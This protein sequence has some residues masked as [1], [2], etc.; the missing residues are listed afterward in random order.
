MERFPLQ[1]VY[2]RT[3]TADARPGARGRARALGRA[4][5]GVCGPGG[6]GHQEQAKQEGPEGDAVGLGH[7]AVDDRPPAPRG[8][9][10]PGDGDRAPLC[11]GVGDGSRGTAALEAAGAGVGGVLGGTKLLDGAVGRVLVRARLTVEPAG[12]TL[13]S[14]DLALPL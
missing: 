14:L 13:G 10:L 6:D 1:K 8:R 9:G 7:L 2:G 3:L 5:S 12:T 4:A 11:A